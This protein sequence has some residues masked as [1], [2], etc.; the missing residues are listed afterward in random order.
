MK[1]TLYTNVSLL[2]KTLLKNKALCFLMIITEDLFNI[3][4]MLQIVCL[5]LLS[6]S[7]FLII[8]IT[9]FYIQYSIFHYTQWNLFSLV[10]L[11]AAVTT[12]MWKKNA[13]Y[14]ITIICSDFYIKF[15]KY[16]MTIIPG[17]CYA[18]M[19]FFDR[20][21]RVEFLSYR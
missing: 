4:H 12:H 16:I 3:L 21:T 19:V 10:L 11:K 20:S 6:A 5:I 7:H 9:Y 17:K 1:T 14:L 18:Y 8:F 2:T 13:K 15:S